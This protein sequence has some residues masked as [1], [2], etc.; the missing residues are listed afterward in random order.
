MKALLLAVASLL[1]GVLHADG[2]PRRGTLNLPLRAIPAD[3]LAKYKLK[4]QGALQVTASPS[5]PGDAKEGDVIV[6]V[7][8]KSF[9]TFGEFNDLVRALPTGKSARLAVLVDG[10]RM[11][12]AVPVVEK[13]V[14]TG[15]K[16]DVHYDEVVSYG[17]RIRTL[18]SVPKTAGRHP[19]LFWIQGINTSSIDQPL[20]AGNYI[21][22]ALKPFADDGFVTVRVEKPGVGDSEGGPAADVGFDEETDIYRQALKAVAAKPYVDASR[23]FIF[24]HSMGGCHAPIVANEFPVR[25]IVTYGT[26]A[27]SWLEWEIKAPRIQGALAGQTQAQIDDGVRKVA[28]F[29]TYV[30]TE[31]RSLAWVRKHHPELKA[32]LD[33]Q[34]PD[35]KTLAPRSVAYMQGCNDKNYCAYWAKT[36]QARVLALFGASDWISLEDD[37]RQVADVVNAAHPGFASFVKVPSIDHLFNRNATMADS[38]SSFGKP[39]SEFNPDLVRVVRDWIDAQSAS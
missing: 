10:K 30:F 39:G 15:D 24:G 37:Q 5:L 31:H 12:R 23:I 29:Y 8:G 27:N 32:T 1:T 35:G 25:G 28:A 6:A 13:P 11:N 21:S 3:L 16:Y 26:V 33:D 18:I 2:L 19:V 14:E 9:S 22:R 7:E 36:G 34:S 17:H 4:P 20:T 38:F